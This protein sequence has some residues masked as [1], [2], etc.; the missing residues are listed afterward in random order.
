MC[1]IGYMGLGGFFK[2]LFGKGEPVVPVAEPAPAG[3][4]GAVDTVGTVPGA[5]M[6]NPVVA[7]PTPVAKTA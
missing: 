1:N 2:K 5:P 3:V 6:G 7:A 4:P